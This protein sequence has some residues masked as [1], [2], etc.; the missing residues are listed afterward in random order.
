MG[1]TSLWP[2]TT[3]CLCHRR[4]TH[5]SYT[6]WPPPLLNCQ[7][8]KSLPDCYVAASASL[9][10]LSTWRPP[11]RCRRSRGTCPIPCCQ[12]ARTPKDQQQTQATKLLLLLLLYL[13]PLCPVE[14]LLS[15]VGGTVFHVSEGSECLLVLT[16]YIAPTK[17]TVASLHSR[18][19]VQGRDY[20]CE[21]L[22]EKERN[23]CVCRADLGLKATQNTSQTKESLRRV[24]I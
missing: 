13:N 3:L 15:S 7:G 6:T 1:F 10:S 24:L 21:K 19:P 16:D 14:M 11:Q 23:I 2:P 17:A 20:F 12:A 8:S 5:H 22:R 18:G 9:P 4:P